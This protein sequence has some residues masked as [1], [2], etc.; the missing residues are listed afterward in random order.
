[1]R[2]QPLLLCVVAGA[3]L[4][5]CNRHAS[6]GDDDESGPQP[7]ATVPVKVGVLK[8]G[9]INVQSEVTGSVEALRKEKVSAPI[10]GRLTEFKVFEGSTV[11][12]GQV[13]AEIQTRESQAAIAGAEALLNAA[14]TPVQ[15]DEARHMLA[16]ARSG[17]TILPVRAHLGG[18]IA[19]RAVTEGDLLTENAELCTVVDPSSFYFRADIPARLLPLIKT[20]QSARIHLAAVQVTGGISATVLAVSPATDPASQTIPARLAF[21]ALTPSLQALLK[22]G[23]AGTAAIV[24]GVHRA[25][26]LAPHSAVLRD[27]ET[28][29][30]S[31][32][33]VGPDSVAC[34]VHV[35]IGAHADSLIEISGGG[36]AP[37]MRVVTEGNYALPDSTHVAVEGE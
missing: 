20:G 21:V 37:G 28:D 13:V 2:I 30:Y 11:R 10:A 4:T 34:Q 9:D 17:Q 23:M 31:L 33:A 7:P 15:R 6:S 36:L 35:A 5:G 26:L 3:L 8:R 25:V 27:D 29:T 14:T 1:M 18:I 16:L 19:S 24:T 12:P 22:A 32:F